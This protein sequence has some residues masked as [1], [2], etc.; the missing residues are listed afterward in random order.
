MRCL[1]KVQ[2]GTSRQQQY[3]FQKL[4]CANQELNFRSFNLAETRRLLACVQSPPLLSHLVIVIYIHMKSWG[5]HVINDSC[6]SVRW[7]ASRIS[8]A[9]SLTRSVAH[10]PTRPLAH[11]LTHSLTTSPIH[12]WVE[13]TTQ[14]SSFYPVTKGYCRCIRLSVCPSVCP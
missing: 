1:A 4:D 11:S 8:L 14:V 13:Y 5:L 7:V 2:S 12:S 6:Q 9:H 10:P 3:H